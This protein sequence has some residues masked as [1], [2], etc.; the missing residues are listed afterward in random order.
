[1]SATGTVIVVLTDD[2]DLAARVGTGIGRPAVASTAGNAPIRALEAETAAREHASLAYRDLQRPVVSIVDGL[3]IAALAGRPGAGLA[4]MLADVG[5][6]GLLAL[7]QDG[8]PRGAV[9]C[10]AIA[11]AD[12]AGVEVFVGSMRGRI[13]DA[14]R[15]GGYGFHAVFE[16]LGATLTLAESAAAGGARA[17]PLD[18]ALAELAAYLRERPAGT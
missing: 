9:A 4:A 16:P 11:Y 1:M 6:A 18:L 8:R 3:A 10:T 13:S 14:V 2:P 12:A 7:L 17:S 5:P 15:G